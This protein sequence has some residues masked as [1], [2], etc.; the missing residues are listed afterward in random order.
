MGNSARLFSLEEKLLKLRVEAYAVGWSCLGQLT[1]YLVIH[2][3][4]ELWQAVLLS[5]LPLSLYIANL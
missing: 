1:G 3:G 5:H 4:L 2:Q